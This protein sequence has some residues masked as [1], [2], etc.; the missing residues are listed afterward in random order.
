V[1][2]EIFISHSSTD[3]K[4]SRTICTALENR[5]LACWI[6]SR[7]VKPG[8]NFQ[9]QIVKAIRAAKIMVLVFTASANNSNEIKKELALASQNNL[10]VIPVRIEDVSPNEAFAYEFAT[11]QWIDLFDNWESSIAR[12]VEL[13][14]AALKEQPSG[15][16]ANAGSAGDAG[17]VVLGNMVGAATAGNQR[18]REPAKAT[19][20]ALPLALGAACL[21]VLVVA[22][23]AYL[24]IVH[25]K[26]PQVAS[27]ANPA[28]TVPAVVAPP[29]APP[30]P[31]RQA[32]ALVPET[33]PI[34]SDRVRDN[35]RKEYMPAEDH[36]ALAISSG[37]IGFITGQPNDEQAKTA[38]L[39][40]C[41]QR[42][43]ALKPPR[44]CELYAVGTTVVYARGHT[45]MPPAPWFREDPVIERP[46]VG[47]DIPLLSDKAKDVVAKS[48]LVGRSPK[49]LAISSSGVFAD[50]YNQDGADEAAR[51]SLELCASIVGLPC[52]IV[53]VNDN[54]VV[55]VP[56]TM[57]AVSFFRPAAATVIAPELRDSVAHR[58]ANAGGWTAVAAGDGGKVGLAANAANEQAALDG[59]ISD[60]SKQD[61]ACHV[62]AIGP[63]AVEPK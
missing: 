5:G 27:Q 39:D 56:T 32:E 25:P 26:A 58:L 61:H 36:K 55:P 7:D 18:Q 63:F 49:A 38:A 51:R 40:M 21:A 42:A 53:A 16:R 33:I 6:S 59:A 50:Y 9:E 35:I 23:V 60:C 12:L 30:Q 54:F 10:I 1:D 43:D 44:H 48:Y 37:P 31:T 46:L 2:P 19:T 15:M 13:I 24:K 3:K 57:K 20:R 52:M 62:I 45:P 47:Q 22:G 4:V 41:Q 17:T 11:R 8:Q 29:A 14:A 28:P 34:V